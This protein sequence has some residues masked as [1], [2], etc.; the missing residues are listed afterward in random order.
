MSIETELK[1][2]RQTI[3][4]LQNQISRVSQDSAPH[5]I[6]SAMHP[7]TT[8]GVVVRGDIITGQGVAPLWEKLAI[9]GANLILVSDGTD[10]S[11][12]NI[13][14]HAAS[15]EAPGGGD[16][17]DHDALLNFVASEHIDWT[18]ASSNFYTAGTVY[19]KSGAVPVIKATRTVTYTNA[20]GIVYGVKMETSGNMA[21]G[22]GGCLMFYI[23]DDG[24][25]ENEIGYIGIKRNGA[26]D[27]GAIVL[28]PYAGGG[29]ASTMVIDSG[30]NVDIGTSEL[31][32]GSI[33]RVAGT[34]ALEIGGTSVIDILS[35]YVNVKKTLF[36]NETTNTGMTLGLTVNQGAASNEILACK[37]STVAHG[38]TNY[39]ETDTFGL[40]KQT[41]SGEGGLNI[42]GITEGIYAFSNEAFYTTDNATKSTAGVGPLY[43]VAYKISG[44]G[45]TDMGADANVMVVR[46]R[47]GGSTQTVFI[48]DVDGDTWQDGGIRTN[49]ISGFGVAVN[50]AIQL[51]SEAPD[52]QL[53]IY[54]GIYGSTYS[55][56]TVNYGVAGRALGG[57]GT[58]N[59]GV[60]GNAAN[61]TNNY[62]FK[63]VHGNYSDASAWQ[64]V[65]DPKKKAY[66][67]DLKSD[68]YTSM[69]EKL[70]DMT[71]KGYRMRDDLQYYDSLQEIP[72]TYGLMANDSRLPQ[73]IVGRDKKGIA[74]GKVA[75]FLLACVKQ[76][77]E[78]IK[79]LNERLKA[80]EN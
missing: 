62:P 23:E 38:C 34:L 51:F 72:E 44:V 1:S 60:Y 26:D 64:D 27:T 13:P 6:L 32:C 48:I 63:D 12:G 18:N 43:F 19:C 3:G 50:P 37:A 15:H 61:A 54:I 52:A 33:N 70:D 36:I 17:V 55:D 5:S 4:S 67:R 66:I 73:F 53:A 74:A 47:K 59:I 80:L 71:I 56:A 30:A 21:D 68:E 49:G 29:V 11:W 41:I 14:T 10:V 24:A 20:I 58:N 25:V 77:K 35:T 75:T 42:R 76:Q 31:T 22:F 7:D 79:Q 69:Y 65:S 40:M 39:A 9:G 57:G 45:I 46:A 16:Q 78:I 28:A 2:L 8:L